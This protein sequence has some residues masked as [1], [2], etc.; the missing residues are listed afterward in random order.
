[1][2]TERKVTAFPEYFFLSRKETALAVIIPALSW[3]FTAV[4]KGERDFWDARCW[5]RN[6]A[7]GR[8]ESGDKNHI[9]V[10]CLAV[11]MNAATVSPGLFVT[12]S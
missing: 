12:L 8:K 5:M 2:Q 3:Q 11:R 7:C 10:C 1:M 4:T 9:D 6:E